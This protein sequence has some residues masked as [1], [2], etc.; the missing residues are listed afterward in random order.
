[1][2]S[3]F[4]QKLSAQMVQF[5]ALGLGEVYAKPCSAFRILGDHKKM[6]WIT[7][8][9]HKSPKNLNL[10]EIAPLP[11]RITLLKRLKNNQVLLKC[12]RR[13]VEAE[14]RSAADESK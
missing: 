3:V 9:G 1:M 12:F 5:M 10:N 2:I 13:K 8:S 11:T 14:K 4:V 7:F 6:K